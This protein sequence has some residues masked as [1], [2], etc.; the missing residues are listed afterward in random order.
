M[1]S[2]LDAYA[3]NYLYLANVFRGTLTPKHVQGI[4][5]F[6]DVAY[7]LIED[8][9]SEID[10]DESPGDGIAGFRQW[11]ELWTITIDGNGLTA[12]AYKP[13][14]GDTFT[15]KDGN[16]WNILEA[17]YPGGVTSSAGIRPTVNIHCV[18][19]VGGK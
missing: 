8:Q 12:G 14:Q 17:K 1:P 5:P 15:D 10:W 13:K 2:F 6:T 11:F 7:R 16:T 3:S 9:E 18:E 4:V 19:Q